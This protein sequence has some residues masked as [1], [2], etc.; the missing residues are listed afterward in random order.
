LGVDYDSCIIGYTN[1]NP[2]PIP[3]SY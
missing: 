3:I 2:I 1:L